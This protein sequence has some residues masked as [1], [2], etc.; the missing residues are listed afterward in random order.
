MD[1]WY[2]TG[3]VYFNTKQ[4]DKAAEFN[5]KALEIDNSFIPAVELL[6]FSYESLKDTVNA[7]KTYKQASE[8]DPQNVSYLFNLGLIFNKQAANASENEEE[9]IKYYSMAEEQFSK[10]INLNPEELDSY[11]RQLFDSNLEIMYSLN[12]IAQIQQKKFEECKNTALTGSIIDY[13]LYEL[14]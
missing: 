7:I 1:G 2:Q 10:A 3:R 11:Q 8:I 14:H 9:K 12:C 5:K 4:Y 6:A 13:L